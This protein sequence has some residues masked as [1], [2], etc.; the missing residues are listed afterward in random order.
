MTNIYYFPKVCQKHYKPI[1]YEI[2]H[3]RYKGTGVLR[4]PACYPD[5][6]MTPAVVSDKYVT[7]DHTNRAADQHGRCGLGSAKFDV[8]EPVYEEFDDLDDARN[9][10]LKEGFAQRQV[11]DCKVE[12]AGWPDWPRKIRGV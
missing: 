1:V 8:S 11:E 6:T 9:Y 2:C 12:A 10:P 3:K 7:V 5:Q 4:C